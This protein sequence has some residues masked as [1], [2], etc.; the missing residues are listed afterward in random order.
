MLIAEQLSVMTEE[1]LEKSDGY[2]RNSGPRRGT[3]Q[4]GH[5]G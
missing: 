3:D 2:I 5:D 4:S 1:A